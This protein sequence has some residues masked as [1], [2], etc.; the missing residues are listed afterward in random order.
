MT[1]SPESSG[2]SSCRAITPPARR[3]YWSARRRTRALRIGRPSSEKPTAPGVAQLGHLGQLLARHPAGDGGD[4][5]DRDRGL[6]LGALADRARAPRRSRRGLGVGHRRSPRSSRRRR[7]RGCPVSMSSLCSWP[8]DAQ[9]DVGVEEGREARAGPRRRSPR[10]PRA[11]RAAR[12]GEL[13]DLAVADDEVAGARRARR[14]GRAGAA[15]RTIRSGAPPPARAV[16]LPLGQRSR[17]LPDRGR[18]ARRGARAR[19]GRGRCRRAARRGSPSAR[20]GP[21]STCAVISDCGES[22][23]SGESSTPRLTGPG[24]ISSWRGPEP[25]GVDLVAGRVLAQR[26]DEA[27]AHPLALHPQG[28]DDV[29][30]AEPVEVVGDL[31]AERLDPARDQGRRAAERHLGAHRL[32]GE[33]AGAGDAAVEDVADDPDPL[34][35]RASR[36]AGAA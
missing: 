16:E 13:G 7:R 28:V 27:L 23:T 32:E 10:R 30:L 6:A 33:Q 2:S 35:R 36:G 9:V 31:A 20:P 12:L 21:L 17:R 11:R 19:G 34:A 3:W 22:I 15:P 25:A 18:L 8:G 1:P 5:A 24:C 26:G 14:A 29:G 4:E